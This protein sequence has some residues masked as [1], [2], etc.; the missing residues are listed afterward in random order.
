MQF[1]ILQVTIMCV[2]VF[3]VDKMNVLIKKISI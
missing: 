2:C 3:V 1:F